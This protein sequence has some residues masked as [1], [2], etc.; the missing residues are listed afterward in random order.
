MSNRLVHTAPAVFIDHDKL[1]MRYTLLL[2]STEVASGNNQN[3]NSFA[4]PALQ[5]F[6]NSTDQI[7]QRTKSDS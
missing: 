1:M 4:Y 5:N 3:R 6:L 2:A 7:Q